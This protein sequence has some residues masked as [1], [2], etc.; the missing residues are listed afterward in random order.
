MDILK[1]TAEA[2]LKMVASGNIED[3]YR[4]YV[5]KNF[6]HHNV[7]FKGDAESL[8]KGMI[9]SAKE[10]PDKKLVVKQVIR[11]GNI[12]ITHSHVRLRLGDPGLALIH[13]FRFEN[14]KIM[15][16]WD[17][18]QPIPKDSVNDNGPF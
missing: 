8:K 2:F 3:A 14:D 11:E 9:E 16:L 4:L 10:Y 6:K 15:E 7:Y 17:I 5:A 12:V 1:S 13:I 18:A